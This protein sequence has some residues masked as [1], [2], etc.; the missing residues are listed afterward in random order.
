MRK[1]P[2]EA[3]SVARDDRL[4]V[5]DPTAAGGGV[6]R[7]EQLV[8]RVALGTREAVEERRLTCVRV[9]HERNGER[10]GA[11]A[12]AALRVTLTRETLELVAKLLHAH[13]DHSAVKLDL[14]FAGAAGLAE[15]AA[16]ALQMSPA[17][18][19][20]RGEMLELGEFDLQAAF[21]GLRAG[22]EDVE[23][24]LG[25]VKNGKLD[26]ALDVSLLGRREGDVED[27]DVGMQLM[28]E[29]SEL[30]NLARADEEGGI[31]LV[32]LGI[33]K[34]DGFESVGLD[35]K[36]KLFGPESA[37]TLRDCALPHSCASVRVLNSV[38]QNSAHPAFPRTS[39]PPACK[40][41]Q[42]R[43]PRPP[44]QSFDMSDR[45]DS[46]TTHPPHPD[47]CTPESPQNTSDSSFIL[48]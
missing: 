19:E 4:L 39:R 22:A 5:A 7:C 8:G 21:A 48:L 44:L 45:T 42:N 38:S 24:Q 25:A 2:D 9:A 47:G 11:G 16:L 34:S 12:R 27:D 3:H 14:L 30:V 37:D 40:E 35:E 10:V 18:H 36:R 33:K 17:A 23:N 32:A 26:G 6:E 20:A 13:A 29:L 41:W 43:L 31:G 28:S 15:A 1:A 46:A